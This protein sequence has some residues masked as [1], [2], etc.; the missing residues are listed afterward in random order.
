MGFKSILNE[1]ITEKMAGRRYQKEG[2]GRFRDT[3]LLCRNGRAY[4]ERFNYG[5]A[6]GQVCGMW[7]TVVP[8]AN[9]IEWEYAACPY[10]GKT[11][12]P[13]ALDT[14]SEDGALVFDGKA[15]RWVLEKKMKTVPRA[16]LSGFRM[17]F[18]RRKG[19]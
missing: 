15:A 2:P 9:M 10:S 11:E 1:I 6:A 4:F 19:L 7:G 5:E 8:E 13:K 17:W 3:V 14:V 12:A 16:G 18:L